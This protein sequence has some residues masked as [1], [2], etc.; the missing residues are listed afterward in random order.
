M[1][2]DSDA[3]VLG[4]S[5]FF[6]GLPENVATT[7]H[8]HSSVR[9]FERGATVFLQGEAATS[10]FVVLNGWVKLYRVSQNGAE[11][12]VG[13]FTKGQ[14][15]AEAVAFQSGAYPVSAEAVTECRLY[16]VNAGLVIELMKSQPEL[17]TA[18]IGATFMHLHELVLQIEQL[19]AHTGAQ[20]VAEFLIDLCP[21]EEGTCTVT[22]PYDKVLI[23]GRLG[24][25]PES[26]SR[27]FIRLRA[28]GVKVRQN[29][30]IIADIE[31]LREYVEEDPAMAWT[32]AR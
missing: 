1:L 15:F 9:T 13:V 18:M 3:K 16:R 7:I 4:N 25:K 2:S 8:S 20:R 5:V 19:K 10:F 24:M 22:L 26:L 31:R 12:I 27:A 30:A 32:R 11:A 23:A 17:C 28:N 14:S 6:R 29:D 21:V